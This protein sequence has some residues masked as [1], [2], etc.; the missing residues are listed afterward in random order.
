MRWCDSHGIGYVLGLAQQ[1]GPGTAWPQTE[2]NRAERQ[3][4][5]SGQPQRIFGSLAYGAASWDRPRRVI[6]KA[7]HTAQGPN[8]R[9]SSGIPG[10]YEKAD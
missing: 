9:G 2:I 8:P 6:A 10:C 1:Q 5:G 3:F 7:E 4:K